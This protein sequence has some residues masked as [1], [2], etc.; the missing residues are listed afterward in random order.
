MRYCCKRLAVAFELEGDR[1]DRR[2][3]IC[4]AMG[5]SGKHGIDSGAGA[6]RI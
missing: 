5:A 6:H 4:S 3:A 2:E 1:Y